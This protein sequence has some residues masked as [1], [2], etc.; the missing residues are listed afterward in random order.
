MKTRNI[1]ATK[2]K[3]TAEARSTQRSRAAIKK[4]HRRDAKGAEFAEKTK[5][6]IA[7][8][9]SE[10]LRCI[11]KHEQKSSRAW[12]QVRATTARFLR[13]IKN[14]T[15]SSAEKGAANNAN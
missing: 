7:I 8:K 11:L 3:L 10:P 12:C 15:I 4:T 9:N 6:K 5:D 2:E 14:F 13:K 1:N